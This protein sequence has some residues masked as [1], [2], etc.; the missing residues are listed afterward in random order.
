MLI[1]IS[2]S[3]MLLTIEVEQGITFEIV[4]SIRLL[5]FLKFL[6]KNTNKS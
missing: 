6:L 4:V 5:I 1:D 2:G 3:L